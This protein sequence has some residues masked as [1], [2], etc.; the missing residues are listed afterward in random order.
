MPINHDAVGDCGPEYEIEWSADDTLFYNIAVGAGMT[1]P[2]GFELQF[3][4]ENTEGVELQALPTA[5]AVLA[6][7]PAAWRAGPM[8][9]LGSWDLAKFRHGAQAIT[10]H[11]PVPPAGRALASARINAI[12]DKGSAAVVVLDTDVV[13]T[14]DRARLFT[15]TMTLFIGGEGGW[16]GD[17]GPSMTNEA[18]DRAPDHVVTQQTRPD[19]ALLYRL[20]NDRVRL[21][22][23]PGFA[24]S[25]GFERPI[26]HGLCT[27]GFVGRAL[28]HTFCDSDASLVR[29]M[30]ARF[31]APVLP[32]ETLETRIWADGTSCRFATYVED[33]AVLDGGSFEWWPGT[34]G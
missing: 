32:G 6:Q 31:A 16:G 3:T 20:V 33:R 24:R 9:R 22:S 11:S 30:R 25:A 19:Q 2:A 27:Y 1:D 18:P 28:V 29:S 10:L 8:G 34:P 21:H 15:S 13:D 12:Y 23:D 4:T 14:I 26:L 17:R 5:A 7:N